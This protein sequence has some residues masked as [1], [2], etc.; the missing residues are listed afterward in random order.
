[1]LWAQSTYCFRQALALD[2]GSRDASNYLQQSFAIRG[3][4][5]ERKSEPCG[6]GAAPDWEGLDRF[7]S[8][9]MRLGDPRSARAALRRA[10]PDVPS[11]VL[12]S[13]I[14]ETYLVEGDTGSAERHFRAALSRRP[15]EVGVWCGLAILFAQAGSAEA[16]LSACRDGLRNGPSRVQREVLCQLRDALSEAVPGPGGERD[17]TAPEGGGR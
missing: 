2:P 16:A 15:G 1:V 9:S 11:W 4:R 8:N 12:E 14:A 7:A 3:I 10:P 6:V 17:R 13:R 5:D